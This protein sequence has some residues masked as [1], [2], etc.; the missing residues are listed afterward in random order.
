VRPLVLA[1]DRAVALDG[2]L[3]AIVPGGTVVRGSVLRVAGAPGAGATTLAF[4]LAAAF[5]AVG[6]WAAAVDLD[7]SLGAL[8]ARE[9]GVALEWFTVVRRVPPSRWAAVTAALLDGVSVVVAD[10]PRGVRVGDARRLVARA[11]ERGAVLVV[12][13]NTWPADAVLT[14]HA[15]GSTWYGL[16]DTG[17]LTGRRMHVRTEGRGAASRVR[18]GDVAAFARA[19]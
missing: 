3:G 12:R 15:D 17:M 2:E 19:V 10:A 6:E 18:T 16:D 7:G 4:G 1:R 13:G 9:A 8:G 5:T 14:L 11:R